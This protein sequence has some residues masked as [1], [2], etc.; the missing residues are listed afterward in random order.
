MGDTSDLRLK[1]A[2]GVVSSRRA[3]STS[4]LDALN[5][6][7]TISELLIVSSRYW[8][9]IHGMK[10]GDITED[11]EGMQIMYTLGRNMAWL[12]KCIEAGKKAGIEA[13]AAEK[14]VFTNFIR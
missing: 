13:P 6:Y 9:E 8:N 11:P 7:F 2:A 12:L 4:A 1:P 3:G 14:W 5:K 10:A